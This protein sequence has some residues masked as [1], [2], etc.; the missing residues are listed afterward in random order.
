MSIFGSDYFGETM[1]LLT[2]DST[3]LADY[4]QREVDSFLLENSIIGYFRTFIL[5]QTIGMTT[6]IF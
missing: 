5:I 1:I 2:S 3:K 6:S 4:C